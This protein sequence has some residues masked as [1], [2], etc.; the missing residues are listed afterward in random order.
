M[1]LKVLLAVTLPLSP[2]IGTVKNPIYNGDVYFMPFLFLD[3]R[4]ME[5]AFINCG[6]RNGELWLSQRSWGKKR[7][8]GANLLCLSVS[9]P[10][11]S[12]VLALVFPSFLFRPFVF[13]PTIPRSLQIRHHPSQWLASLSSPWLCSRFRP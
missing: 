11:R 3:L 7:Q 10:P 13:P 1:R 5:I 12:F 2:R 6:N 8:R 9:L 4:L